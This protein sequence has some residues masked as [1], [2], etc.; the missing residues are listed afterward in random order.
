MLLRAGCGRYITKAL[1]A[2]LEMLLL[3]FLGRRRI[4]SLTNWRSRHY[5]RRGNPARGSTVH[6]QL[7]IFSDGSKSV[8]DRASGVLLPERLDQ[9]HVN[10]EIECWIFSSN[11]LDF[12]L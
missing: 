2:L 6:G 5:N 4:H 11:S 12:P 9:G 1:S 10:V 7:M 8:L 3:F